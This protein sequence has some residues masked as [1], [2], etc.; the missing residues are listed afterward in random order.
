MSATVRVQCSGQ[1][2]L[3]ERWKNLSTT[4]GLA[5]LCRRGLPLL[6][7]KH[8]LS[9]KWDQGGR[10][11]EEQWGAGLC[12]LPLYFDGCWVPLPFFKA[13]NESEFRRDKA[14]IPSYSITLLMQLHLTLIASLPIINSAILSCVSDLLPCNKQDA[15]FGCGKQHVSSRWR[16]FS[17][18]FQTALISPMAWESCDLRKPCRWLKARSITSPRSTLWVSCSQCSWFPQELTLSMSY[19]RDFKQAGPCQRGAQWY[20][21]E[22]EQKDMTFQ[23]LSLFFFCL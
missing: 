22:P 14:F 12:C 13:V 4:L 16:E 20:F 19:S 7:F 17:N 5:F 23:V 8:C 11:A 15:M 21:G 18:D 1:L 3:C 6:P 2:W 9:E 10:R